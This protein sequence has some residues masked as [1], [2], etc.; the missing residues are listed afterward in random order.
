MSINEKL[1]IASTILSRVGA[2]ALIAMMLLTATDVVGRMFNS[3]VL[4]ALELTEYLVL[5]VI[6]TMLSYT[7]AEKGHV[8]VDL[9]V[10]NFS[11]KTQLIIDICTNIICLLLMGLIAYKGYYYALDA[12]EAGVASPNLYI[13]KYPLAF[14]MVLCTGVMCLEFLRTLIELFL[15]LKEHDAS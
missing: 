13:P 15:Q 6:L 11:P 3:P 4:G 8:N 5:I 9:V 7:Q 10:R 2:V 14:F 1:R 12:M